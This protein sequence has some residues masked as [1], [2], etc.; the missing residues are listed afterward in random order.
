M[1][2]YPLDFLWEK[3]E[4]KYSGEE[5]KTI[6]GV[7]VSYRDE[8]YAAVLITFED[9]KLKDIKVDQGISNEPYRSS[10]FFL[11]EAPVIS[12][13]IYGE[14]IDLLFVNG[15]G[16]CHPY[17]YGLATVIGFT[18]SILTIGIAQRLISGTYEEIESGYPDITYIAQ[19]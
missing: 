3:V 8:K 5:A 4:K 6:S 1:V 12:K 9:E 7:N 16:I 2:P 13:L 14:S 15:H 10:L 19:N 11:K 17:L 18:H